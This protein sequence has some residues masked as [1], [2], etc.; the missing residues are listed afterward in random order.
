MSIEE[1]RLHRTILAE[2]LVAALMAY[3]DNE[4]EFIQH[5]MRVVDAELG[6]AIDAALDEYCE[7]HNLCP[8]CGQETQQ[9]QYVLNVHPYGST[10]ATEYGYQRMCG[11]CGWR[12][13][14]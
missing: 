3:T 14:E 9:K 13:N 7:E 8:E 10:T 11:A 5:Y 1:K 6:S 2:S 4:V 12:E